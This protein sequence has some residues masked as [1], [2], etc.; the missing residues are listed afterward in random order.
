MVPLFLLMAGYKL[1]CI[2]ACCLAKAIFLNAFYITGWTIKK[3]L[4]VMRV[5]LGH[6]FSLLLQLVDAVLLGARG[7]V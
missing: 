2:R 6:F 4:V 3:A 1:S 7:L 5:R